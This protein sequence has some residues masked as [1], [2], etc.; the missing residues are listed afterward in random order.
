MTETMK[1]RCGHPTSS[2]PCNRP[3]GH[4]ANGHKSKQILS[5]P[6]STSIKDPEALKEMEKA[7]HQKALVAIKNAEA[8]KV[9]AYNKLVAAAAAMGYELVKLEDPAP[10]EAD[11]A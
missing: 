5:R 9:Q 3:E 10:S 4:S 8:K 2:G 11:N 6:R 7:R 1:P